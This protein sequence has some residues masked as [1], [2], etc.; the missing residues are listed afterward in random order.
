MKVIHFAA[1]AALV[2]SASA[3]AAQTNTGCQGN[4]P[5]TGA[6]VGDITTQGGA[7]GNAYGGQGGSSNAVSVGTGVGFGGTGGSGGAG[8]AG[9]SG[10]TGGAVVG[11]GNSS[12]SSAVNGSGN[13]S[14]RNTLGQGQHQTATGGAVNG[15]GNAS[16]SSLNDN[17][18]SAAGN[19]THVSVQGDT[20]SYQA[21][22]IPV[23]T[24]YAPNIAPTALC[25]F[26]VSGGGQGM[27]F[28]FSVGV[29]ITD[30]NCMLLEQVR[31]VSVILGQKEIA[32]EMMMAVPAYADAVKRMQGAKSG[33]AD[34][35]KPVSVAAKPEYTDPI[36]RSRLGLPPLR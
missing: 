29:S 9:G 11:S 36:V 3:H 33:P 23:A 18:S 1:I 6:G 25:K 2:M 21:A 8:G 16:Q 14:N 34:D 28:G 35:V 5:T 22:R 30:D 17:A 27:T 12:S 24:A 13:S 7:G 19:T 10:G 32:Q 26:G 15:S 4:C 20:V 31:T